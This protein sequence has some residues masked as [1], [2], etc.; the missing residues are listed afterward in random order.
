[1]PYSVSQS[2]TAFQRLRPVSPSVRLAQ[3]YHV[4]KEKTATALYALSCQ[5]VAQ[6]NEV[7]LDAGQ[8][9]VVMAH[10]AEV[11]ASMLPRPAVDLLT[12]LH[13][14]EMAD[15]FE[16]IPDETFRDKLRRGTATVG[17]ARE[18]VRKSVV[19]RYKAEQA[20][21]S[22]LNWIAKQQEGA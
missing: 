2:G 3:V 13:E 6:G 10:M 11:D 4:A 15:C 18:Y 16:Q 20:E 5:R 7:Y 8:M 19:A 1:M 14:A 12:A 9:D 17:D 21:Q 22:V